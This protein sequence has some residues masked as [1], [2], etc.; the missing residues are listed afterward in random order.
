V[1]TT[2]TASVTCP[3]CGHPCEFDPRTIILYTH[4]RACGDPITI[5]EKAKPIQ[6]ERIADDQPDWSI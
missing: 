5:V 3:A 1:T 4:C 6:H 2:E